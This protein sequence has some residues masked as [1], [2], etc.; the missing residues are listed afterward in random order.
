MMSWTPLDD[1]RKL[2]CIHVGPVELC[3]GD[4]VVLR[5]RR[6]A[7]VLD[8]A[9]RGKIATIE[10]IEQDLEGQIYL[11]VTVDDDPGN[12]LDCDGHP[13]VHQR[14]VTGRQQLRHG[15]GRRRCHGLHCEGLLT[16]PEHIHRMFGV[17]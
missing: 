15:V 14:G 16:V 4:R 17:D 12:D 7:D 5:P 11:A 6:R 10:S 8:L 9:L 13:A 2:E 1:R 3:A